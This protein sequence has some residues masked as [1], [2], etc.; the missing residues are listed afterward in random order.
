MNTRWRAWLALALGFCAGNIT[1]WLCLQREPHAPTVQLL[2]DAR[3]ALVVGDYAEAERLA[4]RALAQSKDSTAGLLIAGEAASRL[5]HLDDAVAYYARVPDTGND[6][7]FKALAAKAD[8][9]FHLGRFAE[10]EAAFRRTL[11]IDSR[12]ELMLHRFAALLDAAGRRWESRPYLLTLVKLGRFTFQEL[13]LLANFDEVVDIGEKT[14][15]ALKAVPG[16]PDPLLLRARLKL[17]DNEDSMVAEMLWRVVRAR[18]SNLE[19]QGLLGEV[20]VD[21]GVDR[22][23]HEWRRQLPAEADRSPAVWFARGL[24]SERNGQ[25]EA[26]ARCYWETIRIEPDHHRANYQMGLVLKTLGRT[27]WAARFV[28]RAEVLKDV[29][30]EVHY[31]YTEGIQ[32][33]RL[34]TIARKLEEL[35][36]CWEAWAWNV[37]IV[38]GGGRE[39]IPD[40]DRLKKF[41]DT[42]NPPQTLDQSNPALHI[43]LMHFPLPDWS[44]SVPSANPVSNLSSMSEVRA[45]FIDSTQS[46]GIRFNYFNGDDLEQKGMKIHQ[47]MGGGIAAF[48]YDGDAWPDLHFTQGAQDVFSDED[49]EHV[50]RLYRN[51]GNGQFADVTFAAGVAENRYS[52]GATAGDYDNDGFSDLFISNIGKSR[53][54]HNN[55]DGT[56]ADATAS[57]GI[58]LDHWSTS[59]LIADLNGDGYPDLYNVTYIRGADVY[60]RICGSESLRACTPLGFDGESDHLLLGMG[61][62]TFRDVTSDAGLAGL[63]GKGLGILA[64]DF[65]RS[66]QLSLVI[67]NDT[68]KNF[69]LANLTPYRGAPPLFEERGV[70]NGIA[71]DRNGLTQANM[72]IAADDCNGDGL[73]DLF[74]T[75]FYNE[76]K[77]LRLQQSDQIFIDATR[78]ANLRDAGFSMLGFGTQF[79]D[80]ELDGLPDLVVANGHVDDWTHK[81]VPFEMQ[82]Q[83]FR[84]VG[85]GRFVEQPASSLGP[86]FEARH[87]GRGLVRLDWNRDGREDFAVSHLSTPSVL[88]TNA[89]ASAGHFL[90]VRLV[91]VNSARD[92]VGAI[93]TLEAGDFTRV[94]EMT[95]GDGYYV[96][97]QR[98]LVFGLGNHER[99]DRLTIHWPSGGQQEIADLAADREYL[100]IENRAAPVSLRRGH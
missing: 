72:G 46:A 80:G 84:N 79:L 93:L 26:A 29:N 69:Y 18:A 2:A 65:E 38:Q 15:E 8:A 74:I 62:G 23:F 44:G 76:S 53:L 6:A 42:S 58:D 68:E 19:A 37:A 95:A 82:P 67:A 30:S 11:E 4:R 66:G 92:A 57:A 71:F 83:Y 35:G 85:Q 12:N 97:N 81:G 70:A 31:A 55:G 22:D 17:L 20:L 45:S 96:S 90:A 88:I 50:D 91:A 86:Y 40:R 36:R 28:R 25:F 49:S 75:T 73:L 33:N 13:C 98:Q 78:D 14:D 21:L 43:D 56:F 9:L 27:N 3:Q 64:A 47:T 100:V 60:D 1:M 94:R 89:T 61:D 32:S 99:I 7:A 41:V 10:S 87:L 48:D 54:Y 63:T 24:W 52:Q 16:D 51:L 59:G 77:T 39:A 5:K 34:P